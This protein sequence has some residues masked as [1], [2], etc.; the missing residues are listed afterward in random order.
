MID[1]LHQHEIFIRYLSPQEETTDI[2]ILIDD[3]IIQNGTQKSK[4]LLL[5]HLVL[6]SA[7][8]FGFHESR[9]QLQ[10]VFF[11]SNFRIWKYN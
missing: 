4:N 6:G 1:E 3:A 9:G 8:A 5:T 2:S 10:K 11:F 7:S